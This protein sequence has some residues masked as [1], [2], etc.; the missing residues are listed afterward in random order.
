MKKDIKDPLIIEFMIYKDNILFDT[1]FIF[2]NND[3]SSGKPESTK[4]DNYVN[5]MVNIWH[6]RN[7]IKVSGYKKI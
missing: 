1:K 3:P 5:F 4:A 7:K 6:N 2:K